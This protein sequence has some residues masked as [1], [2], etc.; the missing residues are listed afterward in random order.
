[1]DISLFISQPTLGEMREPCLHF[2]MWVEELVCFVLL[3]LAVSGIQEEFVPFNG[4]GVLTKQE[5]RL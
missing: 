2:R 4:L 5:S 3:F 1:M